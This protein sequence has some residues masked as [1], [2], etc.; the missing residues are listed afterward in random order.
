MKGARIVV[1]CLLERGVT[2]VFAYPG[3]SIMPLLSEI[4]KEKRI[5]LYMN[6]TEQFC[7]FAADGY[8]RSSGKVGVC[9][10]TSGPGATNL[11]TG[12]ANANADSIPLVAIT[13]N[14]PLSL[15][16]TDAFQEVDIAGITMPITKHNFIVKNIK[17]LVPTLISAFEIADSGRKGPVPVDIPSDLFDSDIK[18]VLP[19]KKAEICE[20]YPNLP[21][22]AS[23][24]NESKSP[25]VC[26]GGGVISSGASEEIKKLVDKLG[27]PVVSTAMG[28]GGFDGS[29]KRF[30]GIVG[31][32]ST[33]DT[34]NVI[35]ECDLFIAVGVRFSDRMLTALKSGGTRKV[36]HI[37]IDDAE[38]D[39]N[40][41][42]CGSL[43]GDAKK[44]LKKL[45]PLI[46]KREERK[47]EKRRD[48]GESVWSIVSE[49]FPDAIY[50][51]EV[52]LHQVEACRKLTVRKPRTLLTSGGLGSMGYGL[53]AAIGAAIANKGKTV[54]NIAGDGSFNMNMQELSTSVTLGLNM[55]ELVMNNSSLGMIETQVVTH[56]RPNY[57]KT[58]SIDYKLLASS[59]GAHGVSVESLPELK[60]ALA[61]AKDVG[62]TWLIE[63]KMKELI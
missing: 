60:K 49:T 17:D 19:E 47:T 6:S 63:Y 23:L 53:P 54:I 11:V 18:F 3:A 52:G 41:S 34:G 1:K 8:A 5:S 57:V 51:T 22:V 58:P 38:I 40:L 55:I 28:V 14:V 37:D 33:A 36:V 46:D 12:I 29:D 13:G 50:T 32:Y 61:E 31:V 20:N 16:G 2:D 62:G 9:I 35:N 56:T 42:P 44:I 48:F 25:L 21:S 7:A 43:T 39:K 30:K 59:M 10:A 26:V 24:I 27:C 45:L 4:D 15:L